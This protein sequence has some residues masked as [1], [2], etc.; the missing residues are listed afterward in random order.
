MLLDFLFSGADIIY[1]ALKAV[2]S[3][4]LRTG[5]MVKGFF[6]ENIKEKVRILAN[7]LMQSGDAEDNTIKSSRK[8][9]PKWFE[10]KM[11]L[12]WIYSRH[13]L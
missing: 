1:N 7:Y 2:N 11:L 6:D 10:G 8:D 9:D 4:F 12:P 5:Q 13:L 3:E